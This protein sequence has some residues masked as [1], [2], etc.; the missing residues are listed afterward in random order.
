[1]IY[2]DTS[3]LA[4][5]FLPELRSAE[6]AAFVRKLQDANQS[7]SHWGR[8]E[9][10]SVLARKVRTGELDAEGAKR[11]DARFENMMGDL[12]AVILPTA[13]DF[14]LAKRFLMQVETGLRA[15]DALHLAVA[16]N[17]GAKAIYSLDRAMIK[18]GKILGLPIGAGISAD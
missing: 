11:A 5:L 7:V 8:V 16:G 10:C 18:A 1:M 15:G 3:F 2:F 17:H 13:D 4:P 6:V 9:F 12:F 14:T